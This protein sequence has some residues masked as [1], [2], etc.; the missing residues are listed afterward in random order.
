MFAVDSKKLIQLQIFL[1][2][3]KRALMYVAEG[4]DYSFCN[5]IVV[6]FV[7]D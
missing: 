1:K 6:V 5:N 4:A 7:A 2:K 3:E